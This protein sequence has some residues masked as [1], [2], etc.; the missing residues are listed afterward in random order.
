MTSILGLSAFYHDSAACLVV[1]GDIVAAAQEE[2]FSRK[3]HDERFPKLAVEYCLSEAGLTPDKLDYVAFYD[4]PLLKFDRLLETYLGFAPA[5]FGS[6]VKA[7][8][9]W[10]KD[11]LYLPRAMRRELPGYKKRFVFTEHH[12][13]HA[14]SAFFPSPFERAAVLT[15]D[16]VGEW[17][18]ASIGIGEGN[19]LRLTHEM[20]FPHSP[21]LLYSA[22]TYF[23]GFKVNSGEYKLM[24]LAP[25]GE[26]KYADLIRE[27]LI[28]LK[29]DGSF[30]MDQSYFNYC[31]GLT[32]TSSKFDKLFGGPPRQ[33]E[34][35]LTQREM[36]L[37]ASVQVV[38]EEILL[39]MSRHVHAI[40]GEKQLCLA[41]GVALNCVANGRILREGPFEDLWIQPAAG[42]A[43]G[44]LGAALFVWHQLLG[45][46]RPCNPKR[47]R[48]RTLHDA[49]I[50]QSPET[51]AL[52][53]AWG[54][55]PDSQHGSL[56]GPRCDEADIKAFLDLKGAKYRHFDS[57]DELCRFVADLIATEN[58]VG[59]MQGRM[60][61]GP[62]ALGSR[63][64]LGDARSPQM[65]S[66][67]NVRIK[68]RESF[69]PFAPS[70]LEER[71][72]EF[73]ETRPHESSP[74]MLLVA[75]VRESKRTQRPADAS[76]LT[77]IDKLKELRSCIPAVT[78][79][80]NSARIQTVDAERHGRYYRLLKAFE[81]QTGSP[82]VINTSFNVRGEPIVLN[83]EHAYRCFLATN[84][85]AL[86][87]ERFVLLKKDQ[88]NA[89]EQTLETYLQE[90]ALD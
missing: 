75:N 42:D 85:D 37:A 17:A 27:K 87:L 4:K 73:F 53:D 35:P 9:V 54:Y 89:A 15:V 34:T 24:G 36:D 80:D 67:M 43:G 41:G 59:W 82:V 29:E 1:D 31:Q 28:D 46:E 22:F 5:G 57:D 72:D 86:V 58:V 38:T 65:Q 50:S 33:P 63:S 62:R 77:G 25:Y 13:S 64:I 23:C 26:P 39:R 69:R 21:G 44:A 81:T 16:G 7:M 8:P 14:A 51:L 40:T 3:K 32:M 2:R 78:H 90:F 60:E 47:Q 74:Y 19:R 18:T 10:L 71:V 68:F 12:E 45:K 49:P 84:M 52:A 66:A 88:A 79:V 48:G 20:H 30:R 83:H 61:F 55:E 76:K 56:L 11:K 70:V 6:F